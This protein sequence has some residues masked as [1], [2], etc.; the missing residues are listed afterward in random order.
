MAIYV[1]FWRLKLSFWVRL[2]SNL[3]YIKFRPNSSSKTL[4]KNNLVDFEFRID[5]NLECGI[6]IE[7][8][9]IL[10]GLTRVAKAYFI[11]ILN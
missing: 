2:T 5:F 9:K 8:K 3:V 6:T 7:L 1:V 11:L 4:Y 10:N